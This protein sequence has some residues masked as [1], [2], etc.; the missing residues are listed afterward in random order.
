MTDTATQELLGVGLYT[1]PDAARLTGL[2]VS[3]VRRWVRGYTFP[4]STEI[5]GR[6][7]ASYPV[8]LSE[9]PPVDS[10][11]AVSFVE[12][13]EILVVAALIHRGVPM[14]SIRLASRRA[15]ERFGT[16]HPFASQ[17]FKTDG[18]GLFVELASK[19]KEFAGLINLVDNQY[20]FPQILNHYLEQIDFDLDTQM[21]NRWWPLGK[22]KPIVVDPAVAFGSPV[23]QGT[24]IPVA[25]IVDACKAGE[26]KK[27]ICSWFDIR[28]QDVSA[29]M[30]FARR[31]RVA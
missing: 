25:V 3:T 24:R 21:A 5:G 17:R 9:L 26:T 23:I 15:A 31:K 7:G 4:C 18:K 27:S 19:S 2:S 29:A 22:T 16:R 20:A 6:Y 11:S 8:V 30:E 13:I 28:P 10:R 12:L 1:I 14:R